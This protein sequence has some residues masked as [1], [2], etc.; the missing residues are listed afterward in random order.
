MLNKAFTLICCVVTALF[1]A[2]CSPATIQ[3]PAATNLPPVSA[4]KPELSIIW[5]ASPPCDNLAKLVTAYPDATVSVICVPLSS[6]HSEIFKA[7][8]S[9]SGSDLVI[10]DS[11]WIGEEVKGGHL[12]E[13]TDFLKQNTDMNDFIPAALAAYGEYPPQSGRYWGAPLMA[14]VQL[15]VYNQ[16]I[17]KEYGLGQL[18]TWDELLSAAQKIK[19]AG[20]Y[21][22]FAW[23]WDE[24]N[25]TLQSGW[26]QLAWDWGGQIWRPDTYQIDGI[27]NS[28]EN[29]AATDFAIKLFQ[30][31]PEGS[32]SWSYPEV[33]TAICS[34]ET[35][36]TIIWNSYGSA[37]I[38]PQ[39]CAAS[40]HLVFAA[41]PAGPRANTL[42]LGGQGISISQYSKNSEAALAFLKW[43]MKKETQIEWAKLHG[44]PAMK[45][46]LA[47]S[48]FLN[49]APYNHLFAKT[50]ER[51]QDYWNIPEYIQL[52]A[53]QGKYLHLAV[54]GQMDSKTALDNIANEQ[55][56]VINTAY[57]NGPDQ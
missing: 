38:D 49:A 35:A 11:Q 29:I 5:Y 19:N 32:G 25:D 18:N 2:G 7:Y 34:G 48:E 36:M 52:L 42:Q 57:P 8:E 6:W 12:L 13:L 46:V 51:T 43:L 41:P 16:S 22:G 20:K 27:I 37:L 1:S 21:S 53:I 30:T 15:L 47:S 4:V 39:K 17:F 26:N 24:H 23:F 33:V 45:S 55:Q 50:F 14:N 54:I 10:G 9:K 31:G 40:S 44:Y 28:P 3:Q 56:A